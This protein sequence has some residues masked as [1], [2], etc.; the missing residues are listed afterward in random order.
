MSEEYFTIQVKK[1]EYTEDINYLK[2]ELFHAECLGGKIEME[3]V[4]RSNYTVWRFECKRCGETA[5]TVS[6]G[7][8]ADLIRAAVNGEET[9][10]GRIKIIPKP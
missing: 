7:F 10:F 4:P 8:P 1:T 2:L 3:K 5:N 6:H 9:T